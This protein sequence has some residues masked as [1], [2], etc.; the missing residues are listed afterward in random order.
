MDGDRA[1]DPLDARQVGRRLDAEIGEVRAA[2]LLVARGTASRVR[3]VGLTFGD[4]VIDALRDDAT[5][6]H[7]RLEPVYGPDDTGC[8]VTVVAIDG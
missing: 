4:A 6:H 7:V 1:R 8:D 5:R 2:I 3:I